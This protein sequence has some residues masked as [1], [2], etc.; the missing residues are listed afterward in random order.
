MKELYMN[1]E[2]MINNGYDFEDISVILDVPLD[3]I[4]SLFK[5]MDAKLE[6]AYDSPERWSL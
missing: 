4:K 3:T 1:V 5:E 6:A 2:D